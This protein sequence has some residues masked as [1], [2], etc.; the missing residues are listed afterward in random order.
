MA[1]PPSSDFAQIDNSV[2]ST[3]A[4][5]A[6][7]PAPAKDD[8]RRRRLD[9][10]SRRRK[11]IAYYKKCLDE[12]PPPERFPSLP[13]I[14]AKQACELSLTS[15][16]LMQLVWLAKLGQN[17]QL[18]QVTQSPMYQFMEAQYQRLAET[19]ELHSLQTSQ[20]K[21]QNQQ[22]MQDYQKE[23]KSKMDLTKKN[24]KLEQ[25]LQSYK[26]KYSNLKVKYVK[27][28]KRQQAA[29]ARR[30]TATT[31]QE[32]PP[33][34]APPG[35]KKPESHKT[36]TTNFPPPEAS[37]RSPESEET[38]IPKGG[39]VQMLPKRNT[40]ATTNPTL[41]NNKKDPPNDGGN[42]QGPIASLNHRST[43][44][45]YHESE[46]LLQETVPTP[47]PRETQI[48]H[49][50]PNDVYEASQITFHNGRTAQGRQKERV[51]AF[52]VPCSDSLPQPTIN[53]RELAQPI[54]T[55]GNESRG[56]EMEVIEKDNGSGAIAHAMW[57]PS[58]SRR[59]TLSPNPKKPSTAASNTSRLNHRYYTGYAP[60]LFR[61]RS[62]APVPD[63]VT[64][65]VITDNVSGMVSASSNP[66]NS[67]VSRPT[68]T[69][70]A[71]TPS[72][73]AR[74]PRQEKA[75][76]KTKR[77]LPG[78]GWMT[79]RHNRD[80]LLE[81]AAK[82]DANDS[83]DN[84]KRSTITATASPYTRRSIP[85][86]P[87]TNPDTTKYEEVVRKKDER[88]KLRRHDC[89]DCG[90]FMDAIMEGDGAEI[91][92]RHQLMCNSRHRT[93]YTP[94]ETP[95]HFWELSFIDEIKKRERVQLDGD[96]GLQEADDDGSNT[97]NHDGAEDESTEV[98]C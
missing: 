9:P 10:T 68:A 56:T 40:V 32:E 98:N 74:A 66:S 47:L 79:N 58:S 31:P 45:D 35:E 2:P 52:C 16:R 46:N 8:R 19:Q 29:V 33:L 21:T 70:P 41:V 65:T 5:T 94:P 81:G 86:A 49:D 50:S 4:A 39:P 97:S 11:Q 73:V 44:L 61:P 6:I 96:A 69:A 23:S 54:L 24:Q 71:N 12:S 48:Y 87:S 64:S 85:G 55:G 53:A 7:T 83:S 17:F 36:K 27:Q 60:N 18:Y 22:L 30:D 28:Y 80:F 91:F 42:S 76:V 67:N 72:A 93:R 92:E 3:T 20:F 78:S 14:R 13:L 59:V 84:R 51:P 1:A 37:N 77:P 34:K 90:K 95:E 43:S 57:K 75:I 89:P 62:T 38:V 82:S 88:E 15:S 63:S 25:D 26:E